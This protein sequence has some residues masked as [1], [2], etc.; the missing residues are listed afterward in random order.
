MRHANLAS[1]PA[2]EERERVQQ[3][4]LAY[5]RLPQSK[6]N[7]IDQLFELLDNSD[8][9]NEQQEIALAV[10]EI[11]VPNLIGL[12]GCAGKTADLEEGVSSET[13]EKVDNYRKHVGAAIRKRRGE[14]DMT[15][16]ELAKRAGILQSHISRLE[17]GK[18]AP[19]ARTIE[20]L[21]RALETE[22]SKLDILYD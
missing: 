8:D 10:A 14:L 19:T 15:Q 2:A 13:K 4:V 16:E 7:R 18:H 3:I 20:R 22:P 21:A 17:D 5:R 9:P 12:K 6:K 1:E 11:L